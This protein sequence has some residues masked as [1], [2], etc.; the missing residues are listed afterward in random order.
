LSAFDAA[1]NTA[2]I[3]TP[4]NGKTISSRVNASLGNAPAAVAAPDAK[5]SAGAT[6]V[7]GR[8]NSNRTAA[9]DAIQE[10]APAT[11]MAT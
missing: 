2:A 4:I 8:E 9:R 5:P 1:F 7:N 6:R 11:E 10:S 3:S